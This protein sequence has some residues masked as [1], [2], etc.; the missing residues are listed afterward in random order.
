MKFWYNPNFLAIVTLLL[1]S[2]PALK[3]LTIPGFYTSHDG[4]T[5]T[6]RI[7]AYYQALADGQFPPRF[8]GNFYNGLGSPIF[9]YIYPIPYL[10]GSAIHRLGF[11][12]A[13]SFKIIMALGFI[14]SAI[15]TYLWLKEVFKS[16][17][18]A[19]LGAL[20]YVWAPYRF[21]LIYVRASIS[22]LLAY[23]FL[24][25]LFYSLT[26]L[27]EKQSLL[28]ISLSAISF[29]LV[30]LSQ[31]LVA[32]IS[33]P[34][35]GGYILI[36]SFHSKSFKYLLKS[37]ISMIWGF[38]IAS[39]TYLPLLFEMKSVHFNEIIRVAY[40]THFV[41]LKQLIRSPWGYGFDMPGAV[42]DQMSFQ[43]GLA[44][45]LVLMLAILLV[46]Y[47][48]FKNFKVARTTPFVLS[49]F[50]LITVVVSVFLML[51][52]LL[53]R[54]IWL[55][56]KLS[57]FIDIPWRFLGITTFALS[58][59][60]AFVARNLKPGLIFLLLVAVVVVANRNH[61]RINQ[62]IA[63]SDS[64]FENYTEHAT[65][66][67]EFTPLWR[68]STKT[69]IGFDIQTK[70]EVISGQAD[71]SHILSKSNQV[72]FSA[73]VKSP[74]SQ[75]RINKFY[76]PGA[77]VEVDGKKLKP[78]ND[79][80]VTDPKNLHLEKEQ[81]GTGLMLI[82]LG[83]GSHQV[84]AKFGETPLRLFADYLSLGLLVLAVGFVVK[85]VK[86]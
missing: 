1:L 9:V 84:T 7:A 39:V 66:Y 11:S 14:L 42:N 17:K 60:S 76:F 81:D 82:N 8:A 34:V 68:Q 58:F 21:L 79:L 36:L 78:F 28:W 46:V 35:I 54:E 43:L 31:N 13:D 23:T 5:H 64:F 12:F 62:A 83:E 2:I 10:A 38:A 45:L 40:D 27:K 37:T 26:K 30:L 67:G 18:A 48:L 15:F 52:T 59:L 16:E 22:E 41:T 19:F 50:F 75:V 80:I 61:L 56:T 86:R 47:F 63:R 44:H 6:A 57:N 74:A 49:V 4:E 77:S 51:D 32:M 55:R 53:I 71:I 24:P 20:F 72:S 69:P 65:Q 33:L 29:S 70:A 73:N 85:N 25:L 3:S